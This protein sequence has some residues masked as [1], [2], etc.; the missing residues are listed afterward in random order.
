MAVPFKVIICPL[1]EDT[2]PI[3]T[4]PPPSSSKRHQNYI[5][6]HNERFAVGYKEAMDISWMKRATKG[7]WILVCII[8][9]YIGSY[10]IIYCIYNA[11]VGLVVAIVSED[12]AGYSCPIH[13]RVV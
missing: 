8:P 12:I 11:S 13:G 7:V 10:I 1:S 2:P 9:S 6:F 4:T 5:I 3:I